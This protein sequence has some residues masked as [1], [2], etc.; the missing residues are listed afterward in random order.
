MQLYETKGECTLILRPT[1]VFICTLVHMELATRE[2]V[3]VHWDSMEA[4][5]VQAVFL[6]TLF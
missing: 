4:V 2:V 1:T 5:L 3:L 6:S